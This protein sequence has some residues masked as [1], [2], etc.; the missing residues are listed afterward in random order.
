MREK[1]T[2]KGL[3]SI[4]VPSRETMASL[5]S[6]SNEYVRNPKPHDCP[7][8]LSYTTL[9]SKTFPCSLTNCNKLLSSTYHGKFPT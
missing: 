8:S 7:I 1:F 4:S 5:T 3:P 6:L 9:A 2:L